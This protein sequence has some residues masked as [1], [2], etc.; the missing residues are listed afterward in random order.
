MKIPRYA[1]RLGSMI[2]KY[3]FERD[4]A[5]LR[6]ILDVVGNACKQVNI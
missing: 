1:H 5:Y 3:G 4:V 2:F 6:E